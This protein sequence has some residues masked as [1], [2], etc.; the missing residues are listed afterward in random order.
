MQT[1]SSPAL[2]AASAAPV[3]FGPSLRFVASALWS[4]GEMVVVAY[5]FGLAILAFGLPIA[6]AVR[7][8]LWAVG[9]L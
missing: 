6:L 1:T 3:G 2:D 9:A 5:A 8:L 4:L 7:L